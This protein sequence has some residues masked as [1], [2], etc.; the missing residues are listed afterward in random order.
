MKESMDKNLLKE[1]FRVRDI[2][3]NKPCRILRKN[4]LW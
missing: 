3:S 2:I 1:N 4:R